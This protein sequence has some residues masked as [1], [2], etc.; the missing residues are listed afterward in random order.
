VTAHNAHGELPIHAL[1]VSQQPSVEAVNYL[2]E[3]YPESLKELTRDGDLP[4]IVAWKSIAS[5]EVI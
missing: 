1:C 2:A 4:V 3:T 5:D